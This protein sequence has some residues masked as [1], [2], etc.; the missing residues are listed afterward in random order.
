MPVTLDLAAE[1]FEELPDVDYVINLAVAKS[2]KWHIALG[3]NA[4]GLGRLMMRYVI[5]S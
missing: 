2:E 3:V 1:E 4:E 5:T